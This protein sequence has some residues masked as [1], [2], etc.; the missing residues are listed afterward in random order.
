M[1]F[2][3]KASAPSATK[4]VAINQ[5]ITRSDIT[6]QPANRNDTTNIPVMI[7]AS[8][9]SAPSATKQVAINHKIT[10]SDITKQPANRNDT[11]NI[12]VMV[13]ASKASAPPVNRMSG[14]C[15]NTKGSFTE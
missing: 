6:K 10:R 3:W 13:F 2:A 11:T 8:K 9:A 15:C 14:R 7:F 5:K 4:Q 12:P 1:V